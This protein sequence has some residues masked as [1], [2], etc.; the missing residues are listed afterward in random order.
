MSQTMFYAALFLWFSRKHPIY[1]LWNF[2]LPLLWHIQL[3]LRIQTVFHPWSFKKWKKNRTKFWIRIYNLDVEHVSG[4][5]ST[6][7]MS[8]L[9]RQQFHTITE[10]KCYC[11]NYRSVTTFSLFPFP[12]LTEQYVWG[13][14]TNQHI[15]LINISKFS[16]KILRQTLI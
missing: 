3:L 13:I 1:F 7:L 16:I 15:N 6:T 5:G 2:K 12:L 11:R 14:N 8:L 10:S 9:K 4:A